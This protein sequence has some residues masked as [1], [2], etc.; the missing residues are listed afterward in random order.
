[1]KQ[2]IGQ[3]KAIPDTVP[4]SLIRWPAI[5]PDT[6][7]T[8]L[9][10]SMINEDSVRVFSLGF[11]FAIGQITSISDQKELGQTFQLLRRQVLRSFH[12]DRLES[13]AL[14]IKDVKKEELKR[15]LKVISQVANG[16]A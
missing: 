11:Q 12:Q 14:R 13:L 3:I 10:P 8:G 6:H 2:Y 15:V 9:Q 1:M 16:F 4:F 7:D 5:H